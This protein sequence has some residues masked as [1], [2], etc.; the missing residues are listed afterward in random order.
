MY[1]GRMN[2]DAEIGISGQTY[3]EYLRCSYSGN[4]SVSYQQF[5]SYLNNAHIVVCM[6][7]LERFSFIKQMLS[8]LKMPSDELLPRFPSAKAL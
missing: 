6:Q 5:S 3:T 2:N 4:F 8:W 1:K 7:R